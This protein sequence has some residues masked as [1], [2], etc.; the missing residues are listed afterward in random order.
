MDYVL[1]ENGNIK[2]TD[3]KP[4]VK[5]GDKEFG[6]DAIGA[7]DRLTALT[8][9]SND[10]RKK[11]GELTTQLEAFSG[12]ED[13]AA[14]IDALQKVKGMS[15]DREKALNDLK[16]TINKTWETKQAEWETEKANINKDLFDE[17]MELIIEAYPAKDSIL[18]SSLKGGSGGQG[19]GDGGS[20]DAPKTS[21]EKISAGLKA[22]NM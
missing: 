14:A 11:V 8:A 19:A 16:D 5:D 6:V 2:V 15:D 20:G 21:Q 1:T 17:A 12:I 3:G 9:E 22:L 4:T 18:K 13:P 10:R 7:N